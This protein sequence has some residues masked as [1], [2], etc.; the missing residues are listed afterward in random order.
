MTTESSAAWLW[1]LRAIGYCAFALG[2][3]PVALAAPLDSLWGSIPL[4]GAVVFLEAEALRAGTVAA[5][6]A[7]G[8]D[9][10]GGIAFRPLRALAA[11]GA[12]KLAEGLIDGVDGWIPMLLSAF[13]WI[14]SAP[15]L[16]ASFGWSLVASQIAPFV[17]GFAFLTLALVLAIRSERLRA[18]GTKAA[19]FV[20]A[21]PWLA[22]LVVALW[23][24]TLAGFWGIDSYAIG[25]P[26][27]FYDSSTM[28]AGLEGPIRFSVAAFAMSTAFLWSVLHLGAQ[29]FRRVRQGRKAQA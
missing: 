8:R 6:L 13:G 20:L 18:G 11:A 19:A 5:L 3:A 10:E 14:G 26:L 21:R 27:S 1:S 9:R 22:D 7:V 29:L 24:Q 23:I 16:P 4:L 2:V 28:G 15:Y 17:T 25:F 12:V